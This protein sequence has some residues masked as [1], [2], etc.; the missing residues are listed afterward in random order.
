[1]SLHDLRA[2]FRWLDESSMDELNTRK[3]QLVKF[4][5]SY[6][7]TEA[8]RTARFYKKL[9]EQELLDRTATKQ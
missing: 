1:M 8:G 5:E 4:I 2:F 6:P 7:K 3:E 9:I